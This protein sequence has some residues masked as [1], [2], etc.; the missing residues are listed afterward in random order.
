MK[1]ERKKA[2]VLFNFAGLTK[3]Q[4]TIICNKV[5]SKYPEHEV[6]QDAKFFKKHK[7]DYNWFACTVEPCVDGV[8]VFHKYS[9]GTRSVMYINSNEFIAI[10]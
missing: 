2:L 1:D 5:K 10:D 6:Y 8:T 7:F 9:Q 4:M 3:A